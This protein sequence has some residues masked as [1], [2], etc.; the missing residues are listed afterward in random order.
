VS[1]CPDTFFLLPELTKS[2]PH[3]HGAGDRDRDG[4]GDTHQAGLGGLQALGRQRG[5]LPQPRDSPGSGQGR[6]RAEPWHEPGSTPEMLSTGSHLASPPQP[7]SPL[8]SSGV[9]RA[10]ARSGLGQ[11]GL[12]GGG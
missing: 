6:Q 5:S 8:S 11:R 12:P 7:R 9:V 4:N 3:R 1:P 10:G 2:Q